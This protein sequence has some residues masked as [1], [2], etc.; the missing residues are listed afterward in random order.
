MGGR[1]SLSWVDDNHLAE[2][3]MAG[4]D[5]PLP[6]QER[7]LPSGSPC[8]RCTILRDAVRYGFVICFVE[9]CPVRVRRNGRR[10]DIR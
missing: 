9:D 8:G 2:H 4:I 3:N 6:P 7:I 5:R 1:H 10:S